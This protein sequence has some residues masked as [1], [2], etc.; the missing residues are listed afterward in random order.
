MLTTTRELVYAA[1][2]AK[3]AALTWTPVV[4]GAASAFVTTGRKLL[5]W[6]DVL[7]ENM[8][9]L[10]QT[11]DN[12]DAAQQRGNPPKWTLQASLYVYV[13]TQ[14]QQVATVIPAQLMNPVLDAIETALTPTPGRQNVQ[15]LGGLV[16]HCWITSIETSEGLFGDL[17]VAKLNVEML[18]PS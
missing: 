2:F 17:E 15:T 16:S 4:V 6:S 11:Q 14:A 12:Q 13:Q 3:M 5:H 9:A 8:P 10:F 18:V 7:P 1:L